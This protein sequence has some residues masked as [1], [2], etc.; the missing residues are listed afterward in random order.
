V[1]EDG[2]ELIDYLRVIWK[3]KKFIIVG[4]VVCIVLGIVWNLRSSVTYHAEAVISIGKVV[5]SQPSSIANFPAL[6]LIETSGSLRETIPIMYGIKGKDSFGCSLNAEIVGNTSMVRLIVEGP[7]RRAKK[8]L[9]AIIDRLIGD[10]HRK[11]EASIIPY[12]LLINRLDADAKAIQERIDLT[13]VRIKE[14]GDVETD[15]NL[16]IV[17]DSK[18][19]DKEISVGRSRDYLRGIQQ[20]R[21]IYDIFV[22]SFTEYTEM[23]GEVETSVIRPNWKRNIM[24]AGV[25]GLMMS[26]FLAFFVEY[27]ANAR[28][29]EE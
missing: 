13:E 15:P 22:D 26:F 6:S 18:M 16:K 27:L 25:I 2:V 24:L 20:Q 17:L 11:T 19:L 21:L 7:D 3:R 10:H 8:L 5:S 4:A 29:R 12:K 28:E 9:K 23:L 14:E 1:N